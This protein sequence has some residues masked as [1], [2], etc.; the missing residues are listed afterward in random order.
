MK[1]IL[2]THSFILK[3]NKL[4]PPDSLDAFGLINIGNTLKGVEVIARLPIAFRIRI[5]YLRITLK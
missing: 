3:C 4:H 1:A 5:G 2:Q